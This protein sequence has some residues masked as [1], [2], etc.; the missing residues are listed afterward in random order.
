MVTA[1]SRGHRRG[2]RKEELAPGSKWS[3]R[4][5]RSSVALAYADRPV[6]KW[7]ADPRQIGR[8]DRSDIPRAFLVRA[9]Q[10]PARPRPRQN[11]LRAS[12]LLTTVEASLRRDAKIINEWLSA[13]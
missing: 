9:S 1:R 2:E 8:R 12:I 7:R 10:M 11:G 13:R 4:S 6:R 3:K 5:A